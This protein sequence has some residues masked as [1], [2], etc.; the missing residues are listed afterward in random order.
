MNK[1]QKLQVRNIVINRHLTT[2]L[3]SNNC[4]FC[5]DGKRENLK[6]VFRYTN[7]IKIDVA[8]IFKEVNCHDFHNMLQTFFD[9]VPESLRHKRIRPLY[10]YNNTYILNAKAKA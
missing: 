7:Y 10:F 9:T 1:A 6:T 2:I 8:I 3:T 4:W 5:D